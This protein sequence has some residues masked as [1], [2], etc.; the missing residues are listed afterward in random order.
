VERHPADSRGLEVMGDPPGAGHPTRVYDVLL[1]PTSDAG[2]FA[3]FQA[4]P[5][6]GNPP[7]ELGRGLSIRQLSDDLSEL[8]MDACTF[9]GHYFFAQR[10]WGTRYALVLEQPLDEAF[11]Y[12]W[13]Q[14]NV[15]RD[16]FVLARLVRDNAYSTEFSGRVTE[17]DD[18]QLRIAPHDG[19]ES[20]EVYRMHRGRDWLDAD[21][22]RELAHLLS[23][24]WS[25]P[26]LPRRLERGHWACEHVAWERFG[27]V[28]LPSLVAALEGML[29]TSRQQLMRQFVTRLP[30]LA[31][32]VGVSSVSKTFCRRMYE[33]RSQGAHGDDIVLF[34]DG[35]AFDENVR[36]VARLQ[37]VLR[38]A[39]R[40]GI[41]DPDFRA[42]FQ[43]AS[44]IRDRW[45]VK[46]RH[47]LWRWRRVRL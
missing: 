22:A 2:T 14:D 18:G 45:P 10:H 43:G 5:P 36:K 30:A 35:T 29:N 20:R 26:A 32:E 34:K 27:D 9:R 39:L 37:D 25:N 16:A 44:S 33:A 6:A 28:V 46:V 4:H 40:R 41:E 8:I 1:V 38:G 12:R 47:R 7:A 19:G 11:R 42:I 31:A 13:D 24:F 17:Y 23:C 21:E 3:E 15:I